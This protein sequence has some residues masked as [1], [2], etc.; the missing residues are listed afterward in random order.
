MN[1]FKLAKGKKG[2][3]EGLT[4]LPKIAIILLI[5]GLIFALAF[6]MFTEQRTETR[7]DLIE[8]YNSTGSTL[9]EA[10]TLADASEALASLDETEDA[11]AKVSGKVGFIVGVIIVVIVL[12]VVLGYLWPMVRQNF[13]G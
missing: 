13:G 1:V 11:T 12:A 2:M 10:E 3:T 7:D 5:V 4:M 9:S 6:Q 8:Y